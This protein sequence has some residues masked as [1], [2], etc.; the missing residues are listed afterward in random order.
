M[1]TI[2]TIVHKI[3]VLNTRQLLKLFS[4]V[5]S[6]DSSSDDA[7]S[8]WLIW[9]KTAEIIAF[10]RVF[11]SAFATVADLSTYEEP[12]LTHKN[13]IIWSMYTFL[14]ILWGILLGIIMLPGAIQAKSRKQRLEFLWVVSIAIAVFLSSASMLI[15][16]NNQPL[17]CALNCNIFS[18]NYTNV[19]NLKG[20]HGARTAF[21][22]VPFMLFGMLIIGIAI[23][24][25]KLSLNSNTN[26]GEIVIE[27]ESIDIVPPKN[28]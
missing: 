21:Q 20:Y 18:R 22:I 9:V 15:G 11:D 16:N 25:F 19:C 10:S 4:G 26:R 27:M 13:T 5:F 1:F 7:G 23:H 14:L 17:G 8:D 28:A 24:W 2:V 6:S 12:C 3:T